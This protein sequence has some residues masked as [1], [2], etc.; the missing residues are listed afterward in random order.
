MILKIGRPAI[1]ISA[2]MTVKHLLYQCRWTIIKLSTLISLPYYALLMILYINIFVVTAQIISSDIGQC[3]QG[4]AVVECRG[5]S[6]HGKSIFIGKDTAGVIEIDALNSQKNFYPIVSAS[7]A[8]V[9]SIVAD[10]SYV[11]ANCGYG[12]IMWF[13]NG[14]VANK[15]STTYLVTSVAMNDTAVISTTEYNWVIIWNKMTG[16]LIKSFQTRDASNGGTARHAVL[17][18]SFLYVSDNSGAFQYDTTT[19]SNTPSRSF[20]PT[21][22]IFKLIVDGGNLYGLEDRGNIHVWSLTNSAT[23]VWSLSSSTVVGGFA[24]SHGYVFF[25]SGSPDYLLSQHDANSGALVRSIG[26]IDKAFSLAILDDKLIVTSQR[27]IVK[28]FA[29]P[30]LMVP[31]TSVARRTTSR[32]PTTKPTTLSEAT[33]QAAD[34]IDQNSQMTTVIETRYAIIIIVTVGLV[35]ALLPIL[36]TVYVFSYRKLPWETTGRSRLRSL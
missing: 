30:E 3:Y 16:Q 1:F 32:L 25:A 29:I 4:T 11:I 10:S 34:G 17:Y 22:I 5:I 35:L 24:M 13:R 15:M 12:V 33:D 14:S 8:T 18:G 20:G 6:I 21:S 2:V 36:F 9:D 27:G 19:S 7:R 31:I 23:R 28:S 26:T